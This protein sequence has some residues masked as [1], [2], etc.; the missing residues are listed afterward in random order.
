MVTDGLVSRTQLLLPRRAVEAT[1]LLEHRQDCSGDR[2]VVR[3]ALSRRQHLPPLPGL[4]I[5]R[6]TDS[7]RHSQAMGC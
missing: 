5:A 1:L 7:R 6:V 4:V 3:L 2:S